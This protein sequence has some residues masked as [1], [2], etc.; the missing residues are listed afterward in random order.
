MEINNIAGCK[1]DGN[2]QNSKFVDVVDVQDYWKEI[3]K[4]KFSNLDEGA[5]IDKIS[6]NAYIDGNY[7]KQAMDLLSIMRST[8]L[9]INIK[10]YKAYKESSILLGMI[11]RFT[12]DL[13]PIFIM[14]LRL[15]KQLKV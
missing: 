2:S 10:L 15:I 4:K 3:I 8:G 14:V 9:E 7:H 5:C 12:P 1:I 6:L 11:K 13:T